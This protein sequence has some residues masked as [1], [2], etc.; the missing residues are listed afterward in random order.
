MK[1]QRRR[2]LKLFIFG[3]TGFLGSTLFSFAEKLKL[4]VLGTSRYINKNQNIIKL[5]VT[6][7]QGLKNAMESFNPD[8]VAWTLLSRDHEDVLLDFGLTNLLSVIKEETK[9]IFLS[10]DAIFSGTTG[11]YKEGDEPVLLHS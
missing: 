2:K 3:A 10:T 9:L 11:G 8:A 6:D 5:D 7:K 1:N 4:Q